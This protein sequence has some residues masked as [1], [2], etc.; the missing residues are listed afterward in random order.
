MCPTGRLSL[1]TH[2]GPREAL[3]TSRVWCAQGSAPQSHVSSCRKS[4]EGLLEPPSITR[5]TIL[6]WK[7]FPP[8]R[9]C[10]LSEVRVVSALLTS[11]LRVACLRPPH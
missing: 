11:S 5:C 7:L 2:W 9:H 4:L 1:L 10:L 3:R 8:K 6:P